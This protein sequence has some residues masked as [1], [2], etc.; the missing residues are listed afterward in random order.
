MSLL[1]QCA[2]CTPEN[3]KL[4]YLKQ[5][6][7][8]LIATVNMERHRL[9][10][11]NNSQFP[12]AKSYLNEFQ[13]SNRNVSVIHMYQNMG[14]AE[15]INAALRERNPGEYCIK[16]DDDLTW[17][18]SGWVEEMERVMGDHPEIGILGLRRDDV[19]GELIEDGELLWNSDIMGT[20]T[21]YSPRLIDTIGAL[22]QFSPHYGFDDTV[23]ATRSL[24]AGFK[25][26]YMKNIRIVNLDTGGTE[27]TEWKKRE[28]G[29]Y[30]QEASIYMD[31]IKNGEI[32]YYIPFYE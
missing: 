14:T 5:T 29:V 16:L 3:G 30:L 6:H 21:M 1:M 17:C 12:E 26:A 19:Y 25:N 7:E 31:K 10:V 11:V 2:Y 20:C 9:I 27:Y 24:A 32:S 13:K 15:G 22:A 23:Y 28:A 18:S 8:S 4:K